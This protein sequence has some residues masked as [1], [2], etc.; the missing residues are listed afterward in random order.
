VREA[1]AADLPVTAA[2][3]PSAALTA[4]VL[5]GLPPDAFLFAGFLPP[6]AAA[7]RGALEQWRELPAT[8]IFFEGPSRLAAA[9]ADMADMLGDRDAAVARELTKRHEEVRRGRLGELA[10]Y[11][12]SAGPP[13]GE[14]VVVVGPPLPPPA[15]PDADIDAR[16]RALLSEYSLRDAVALLAAETALSRRTLYERALAVQKHKAEE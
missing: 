6:R 7:R 13:R 5:S 10:A 14:A 16:L 3:G 4:L 11:Y 9:L 15:V 1:L 8:L 12:R 2:P